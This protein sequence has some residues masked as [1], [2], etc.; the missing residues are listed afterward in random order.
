MQIF[1]YGT[2]HSSRFRVGRFRV[3]DVTDS[4]TFGVLLN[5]NIVSSWSE[6]A[7]VPSI[8]AAGKNF[9]IFG[10]L[11]NMI[12]SFLYAAGENFGKFGGP[13]VSHLFKKF[14]SLGG[15]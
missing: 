3:S 9:K 12:P 1:K 15:V 14:P 11:I 13:Y 5:T 10:K 8:S 2:P 7:L 6:S 4:S